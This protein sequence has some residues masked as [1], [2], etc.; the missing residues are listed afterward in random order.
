V[1]RKMQAHI[2][3]QVGIGLVGHGE[4]P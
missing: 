1:R 3:R 4:D 2:V